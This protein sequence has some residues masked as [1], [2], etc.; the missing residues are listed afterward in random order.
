MKSRSG[1]ARLRERAEQLFTKTFD[2]TARTARSAREA[3]L[4][5]LREKMARL[6]ALRE[7]KAS[8]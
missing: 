1:D 4:E 7:G 2:K 5:A 6:R 8:S 3:E